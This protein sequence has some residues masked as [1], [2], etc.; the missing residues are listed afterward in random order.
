[1]RPAIRR[2][3][4]DAL[5]RSPAASSFRTMCPHVLLPTTDDFHVGCPRLFRPTT[6]PPPYWHLPV[7]P[8]RLSAVEAV[9]LTL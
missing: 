8:E 1:M 2:F 4:N 5:L 9:A 7:I 3:L 6:K